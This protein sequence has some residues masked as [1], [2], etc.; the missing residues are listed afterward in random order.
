MGPEVVLTWQEESSTDGS[1]LRTQG[2]CGLRVLQ[3]RSGEDI[4]ARYR[5]MEGGGAAVVL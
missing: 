4:T 5:G 2:L 3:G 1:G